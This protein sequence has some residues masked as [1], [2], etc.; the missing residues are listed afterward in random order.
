MV[1]GG[2][3][4]HHP[5]LQSGQRLGEDY[6][7]LEDRND[8]VR[9]GVRVRDRDRVRDRVRVRVRVK[10]RVFFSSVRSE[11]RNIQESNSGC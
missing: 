11:D 3:S 8:R 10:V 1:L 6:R 4:Y 5:I 2:S 9:V 7:D